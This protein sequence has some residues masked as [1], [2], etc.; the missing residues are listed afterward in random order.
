[1]RQPLLLQL[2]NVHVPLFFKEIIDALNIPVDAQSAV[3][4]V[5]G[6]VILACTS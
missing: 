5:C 6:S 1:M 4:A 2:L 3:W